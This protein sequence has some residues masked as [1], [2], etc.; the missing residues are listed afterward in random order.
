MFQNLESGLLA[1]LLVTRSSERGSWP[2]YE[3]SKKLLGTR[4]PLWLT[5]QSDASRSPIDGLEAH[6][7]LIYIYKYIIYG[8]G[9]KPGTP[10]NMKNKVSPRTQKQKEAHNP[11]KINKHKTKHQPPPGF[12]ATMIFQASRF[13]CNTAPL[14]SQRA[15]A[16]HGAALPP[17]MLRSTCA[18]TRSSLQ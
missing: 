14:T 10:P 15:S 12:V 9:S 3:P 7:S 6:M 16:K 8:D 4:I 2:Y 11:G 17:P 13:W 5:S 1:S 18:L